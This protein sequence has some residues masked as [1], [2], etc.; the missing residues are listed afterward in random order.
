MEDLKSAITNYCIVGLLLAVPAGYMISDQSYQWFGILLFAFISSALWVTGAVWPL[1]Q[2]EAL[3]PGL[4]NG[5]AAIGAL[6]AA[7]SSVTYPRALG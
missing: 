1:F 4:A 6:I 3:P 7:A 2:P 5:A